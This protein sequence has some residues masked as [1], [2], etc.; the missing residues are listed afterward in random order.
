METVGVLKWMH[1]DTMRV[2]WTL[3][4]LISIFLH[5]L[6]IGVVAVL[7]VHLLET[8][9]GAPKKLRVEVAHSAVKRVPKKIVESSIGSKEEKKEEKK[10]P[11]FVKT[12]E[13]Q[14]L[15]TT[16]KEAPYIGARPTKA[17]GGPKAPNDI[18]ELPAQDGEDPRH[19]EIVLFNQ[20][21]QDGDLS[22]D[23][24]G[25]PAQTPSAQ[26]QRFVDQS[27]YLDSNE[28]LVDTSEIR[29]QLIP[30]EGNS[31]LAGQGRVGREQSM[32]ERTSTI[33]SKKNEENSTELPKDDLRVAE[34]SD[35]SHLPEDQ[36]KTDS[37]QKQND[38]LTQESLEAEK[39]HESDHSGS[40]LDM[41]NAMQSERLTQ[42]PAPSQQQGN[43]I[44]LG[45]ATS[46]SI[47]I[48]LSVSGNSSQ[49]QSNMPQ[50]NSGR[51]PVYDPAFSA[52]SQ[53]GFRTAERKTRI[54]GHFSFGHRAS[55]NVA[56]TPVGRY[57]E[58]VYRAIG[59]CWYHQCDVNRDL[60]VTG[61]IRTRILLNPEGHVVSIRQL[62]R[63][64][65]SEAQKSF[66]FVAIQQAPIPPMPPDVRKELI[67]NRMELFFDFFF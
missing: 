57:Q 45:G 59:M 33:E 23:T 19:D 58:L 22:S 42:L 38:G 20:E 39:V 36:Q 21:R 6:G 50:N 17:E 26:V 1:E 15:D 47:P 40:V 34:N 43:E 3:C 48:P 5:F 9:S 61:T 7:P 55:L 35:D 32:A 11:A 8:K 41:L 10:Q 46:Q 16:P 4:L 29:P 37:S 67:G 56:A 63:D 65:A 18:K 24:E 49:N 62:S 14:P 60:I 51:R 66:T 25:R 53:P 13:D 27:R 44:A 31:A 52:E 54:S 64:G 12:S 30:H 28:N 2:S